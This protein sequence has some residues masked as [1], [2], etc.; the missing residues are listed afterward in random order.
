LAPSFSAGRIC[1]LRNSDAHDE[2]HPARN[3]GARRRTNLDKGWRSRR[4]IEIEGFGHRYFALSRKWGASL[5][6][7]FR[8]VLLNQAVA[9]MSREPI[10]GTRMPPDGFGSKSDRQRPARHSNCLY[11]PVV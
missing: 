9:R 1:S 3:A 4:F 7:T 8:A 2:G 11:R 6:L 10:E 5:P